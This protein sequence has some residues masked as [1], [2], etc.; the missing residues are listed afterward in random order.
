MKQSEALRYENQSEESTV[1][2]RGLLTAG[3]TFGAAVCAQA[4][5]SNAAG[6]LAKKPWIVPIP[7][8]TKL[9][10]MEE[11]LRTPDFN[12]TADEMHELEESV[13]KFAIVGD[14]YPPEEQSRISR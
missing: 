13:S 10:H 7:G 3:P 9:A 8:T 14:R 1:S 2:R 12:F 11:N 6:A 5:L 4:A